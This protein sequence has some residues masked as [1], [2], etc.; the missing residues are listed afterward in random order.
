M[1]KDRAS[2]TSPTRRPFWHVKS[3]LIGLF[4]TSLVLLLHVLDPALLR[5]FDRLTSDVR[6]RLR[7]PKVPG[8]EVVIVA[9]DEKSIDDKDLGRWPWPYNVQA[10]LVDQ[11]TAYGASSI[12]FDVVFSSSDTS[13]G[14]KQWH[15]LKDHIELH[16]GSATPTLQAL[17]DRKLAEADHDSQFATA[18][19]RSGRT[20]LGYFFHWEQRTTAHLNEPEMEQFFTH[21]RHSK[22]N[23]VTKIDG[24][25][26]RA[27]RLQSAWAV[28][29]NIAILSQAA[30]GNGFF[31]NDA[32]EDGAIR[33]YPLVVQYRDRVEIPGQQD[34]LFAPLGIRVL[35]RFL[36]GQTMLSISPEGVALVALVGSR[37]VRIPTNTQ[38]EMLINHR[39]PGGTF[40]YYSA[41][42]VI[43]GRH[44]TAPPEAFRDKIVLVGAT[45]DALKDLRVTPFDPVLPGVEIHAAIIDSI[46]HNDFLVEPWWGSPY[47][48]VSILL[49]G[50]FLTILLARVGALWGTLSTAILLVGMAV[51]NYTLFVQAGLWLNLIYPLL[52]IVV[53]WAAMTLYNLVVERQRRNYLKRIF[54]VYVPSKLLAQMEPAQVEPELGG[55]SGMHTAYFTDIASFS[56]FSEVL[57]PTQLVHLLL[58]YLTAM[59][60]ILEE[61]EGTLDKYEGDA[62]VAFFGAPVHLSD[63]AERAV[64]TAVKMQQ[65]LARLRR[66]WASEGEQWPDLVHEMRMR[67]GICAGEFVTGNMG[68]IKRMNYTMM[69]DV[70]NTAARL[71]AS[72]KQYGVYI[73]CTTET[74]QMAGADAFEW[75]FLDRVR[76]VGKTLPVE[77]VEILAMKGELSS[78]LMQMRAVFHQGLDLYKQRAWDEA[79][80]KFAES[81]KYE[82][83]FS[84]RPTTPSR[85]YIERCEYFKV[86]PPEPDWDGSWTLTS[87]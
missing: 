5:S 80:A 54:E 79:L 63:H 64:R 48:A 38:G 87:K 57:T 21:I 78:E 56:S 71:E 58:E 35:E 84:R 12:G 2:Q 1:K 43:K 29:S 76:V 39:G 31:N 11:L 74:L 86:T 65:E 68:S 50:S 45:A 37:N 27:L 40:P 6:F 46:L 22:Y 41:V 15:D 55:K 51:L 36:Q 53:V 62:I 30:W 7:G 13:A 25:S 77:T 60:D 18:L 72:A 44:D 81:D 34:C 3:P 47:T 8:P 52:S 16:P 14:I 82:E 69:G 67:I 17:V 9:L 59:T 33:R 83:K 26:L 19:Q 73:Q 20:I 23:A 70:V 42:D 85:V 32:D 24:A 10:G 75:R 28:E 66:K 49:L 4:L 61:E